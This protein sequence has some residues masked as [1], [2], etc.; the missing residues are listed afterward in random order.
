M[1]AADTAVHNANKKEMFKNC[2]PFTDCITEITN[3]QI[4]DAQKLMQ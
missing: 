4:D 2:T 3:T 1:A